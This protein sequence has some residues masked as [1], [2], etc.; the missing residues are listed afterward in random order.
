MSGARIPKDPRLELIVSSY[1]RLTGRRLLE[2]TDAQAVWRAPRAIVA[3]DTR[4][5]P[6]FF[7]GN[8]MALQL[9]GMS[10]EE[11]TRL[12]SR[13]SAEPE[14]QAARVVLMEKVTREGFVDGYSGMRIAKNGRR[15]MITEVTV[16]N[17]LDEAGVYHGQAA[18]FIAGE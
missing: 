1:Q 6:V 14:A 3:H 7:Y 5:D 12:P 13:L 4:D 11:F 10:F 17:L 2:S 16:W 8:Q 15:F 9:F 18:T